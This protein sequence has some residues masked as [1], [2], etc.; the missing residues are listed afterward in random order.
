MNRLLQGD[1]G[2]GKTVVA[3]LAATMVNASG[4]QAAIMAPT[5]ILAEQH[6][7][8][9]LAI[10]AAEEAFSSLPRS[11]CWLVIPPPPEK[12]EIRLGLADGSIL[13]VIGT[14]ALLEDPVAFKDLQFVTIDEQHRFG[15]EQRAVLR[16]KGTNPHLLV[17]T[18][19]PIRVR[20]PSPFMATLTFPS[21]MSCP[22]PPAHRNLRAYSH[23]T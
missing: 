3:A 16:S 1:V 20:S 12:E 2:S 19:T 15:V 21:W 13:I 17:M 5:S 10:L 11:A 23:R 18:A 6:Y 8:T 9:F 22:W 7:R 14:H 4:A